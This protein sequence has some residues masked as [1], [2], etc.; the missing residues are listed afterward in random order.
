MSDPGT[1]AAAVPPPAGLGQRLVRA[2]EQRGLGVLQAAEKL[3]LEPQVIEALEAENFE[4]LGAAVYVRGHL[5]RYADLLG[6]NAAE[7]QSLYAGRAHA[8]ATPDLTRVIT[9]R[10][11]GAAPGARLGVWQGG[12]LTL[13]LVVAA[14]VWWAVRSGP[15]APPASPS[16][17]GAVSAPGDTSPPGGAASAPA[18][19]MPA[20][21]Q[22]EAAV[23]T[24]PSTREA[25]AAPPAARPSST[26]PA[27][28]RAGAFTVQD[29]PVAAAA[30]P[31]AAPAAASAPAA[32]A[33]VA[34]AA[35]VGAP[36][37]AAP[38]SST[39]VA[40]NAAHV[41]LRFREDSWAEVYDAH[42]TALYRDIAPAGAV[43]E[44]SGASPLR[45]VLGNAAAVG[46]SVNGRNVSLGAALQATP[47]ARFSLDRS[48]R[49]SES[50]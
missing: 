6:E 50:P 33:V 30:P 3:H 37:A 7:L 44:L 17:P 42:G 36:A 15:V 28:E 11:R 19:G 2:R 41:V 5:Q 8:H 26:V 46:I 13:A 1:E 22:R 16:G 20:A 14:L 48:G 23:R 21:T 12:L 34:G 27:S 18:S 38:P 39:P 45:L 9:E 35:V 29:A 24:V 47:N 25:A 40:A 4:A 43:R 10:N 32:G 31:V 49:V